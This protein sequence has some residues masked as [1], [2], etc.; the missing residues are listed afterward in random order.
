MSRDAQQL[1]QQALQQLQLQMT[2]ATFDT[3]LRGSR[4]VGID[5]DEIMV[6]VR[7]AYAVDWLQSRLQRLIE[8]TVERL[9]G[10]RLQVLYT[11]CLP[12]GETSPIVERPDDPP[13]EIL[14]AVRED[15]V[16][17]T[18]DGQALTWRDFYIKLKVAFRKRALAKLKGAPLSVFLCLALHVDRDGVAYPGI[19]TI[20]KETA[21]SRSVVCNALLE[22]ARLGLV[23]K[24][25][26]PQRGADE[27]AVKGYAWFGQQ[28]A[29]ALWEEGGDSHSSET[30]L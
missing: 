20:M 3:W 25:R 24:T 8:S 7:N 13:E 12:E 14:E 6:Y 23:E 21:Y 22:L 28:P 29:P 18:H 11:V 19:E 15:R 2:R 17:V 30:E 10:Q 27:Y 5:G 4:A 26:R 9:A 1:W 16:Q